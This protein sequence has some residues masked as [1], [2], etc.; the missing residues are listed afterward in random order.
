MIFQVTP[1]FDHFNLMDGMVSVMIPLFDAY[2]GAS[3][4]IQQ[5]HWCQ[6]CHMTSHIPP[7]QSYFLNECNG[8]IGDVV[9]IM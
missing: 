4:V 8:T 6:W 9:R 7:F 3:R 2:A 1:Y 5:Q